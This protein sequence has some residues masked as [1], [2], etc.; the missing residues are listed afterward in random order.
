LADHGICPGRM[1]EPIGPG[2][3]RMESKRNVGWVGELP[4]RNMC[5]PSGTGLRSVSDR[6][7]SER[8]DRSIRSSTFLLSYENSKSPGNVRGRR[9]KDGQGQWRTIVDTDGR[10]IGLQADLVPPH[11]LST[12]WLLRRDGADASGD[13]W[14]SLHHHLVILLR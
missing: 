4:A 14:P 7:S 3:V 10:R 8:L 12:V 1:G 13:G 2:L 6:R 9:P 11:N 5:R